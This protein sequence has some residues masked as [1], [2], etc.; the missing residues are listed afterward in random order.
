MKV[1]EKEELV[2]GL[3]EPHVLVVSDGVLPK[4]GVVVVA[5]PVPKENPPVVAGFENAPNEGVDREG[6]EGAPNVPNEGVEDAPNVPNE[7]DGVEAG[8]D[9]PKSEG[10]DD[11][12]PKDRDGVELAPNKDGV[13]VEE[14]MP[15]PNPPV[16]AVEV[17]V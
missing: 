1:D 17:L 3:N 6:V 4:E 12:V 10:V 16:G 7:S 15:N 14:D 13:V 2:D 11:E 9:D 5:A 8:V